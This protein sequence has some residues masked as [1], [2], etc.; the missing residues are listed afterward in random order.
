MHVH[1]K[2]E[3]RRAS[4]YLV[5]ELAEYFGVPRNRMGVLLRDRDMC[6]VF[7]SLDTILWLGEKF[8]DNLEKKKTVR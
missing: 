2:K 7:G 3:D 6:N 1:K 8:K 5:R 4:V